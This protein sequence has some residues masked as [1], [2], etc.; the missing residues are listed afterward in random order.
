VESSLALWVLEG[1]A[2]TID[3]EECLARYLSTNET[4]IASLSTLDFEAK[5][6]LRT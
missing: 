4:A 1:V 2:S 6:N 3:L 5:K